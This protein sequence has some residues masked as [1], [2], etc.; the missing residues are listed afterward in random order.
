MFSID[1]RVDF[2]QQLKQLE[3][4]KQQVP[5]AIASALTATAQDVQ[6]EVRREMPSRFIVRSAWIAK[7]VRIKAATKTNLTAIVHDVD[8]FMNIQEAGGT[9]T[10]INHRVFDYGKWLAVPLDARRNKRDIVRKEDWPANL[11]NPFILTAKDGRHYLAIHALSKRVRGGKG[12]MTIG[13]QVGGSTGTR[14]M[15]TL[16]ERAEVKKRFGF[17]ETAKRVI[18]QR[19]ARQLD[20]AMARAIATAR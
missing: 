1:V 12:M 7:G 5:F 17:T 18:A 3:T 9:K 13:K 20:V 6:A 14:L 19:F 8:P 4:L 16:V 10:S 2:S 11:Q 15:Y